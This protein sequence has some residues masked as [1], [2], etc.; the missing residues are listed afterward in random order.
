MKKPANEGR[1]FHAGGGGHRPPSPLRPPPPGA[2]W[3]GARVRERRATLP[4]GC[5]LRSLACQRSLRSRVFD[6]RGAARDHRLV[7]HGGAPRVGILYATAAAALFGLST[8]AAKLLVG[9]VPPVLLASLLYLG[10]GLG[11]VT[12]HL[13]RRARRVAIAP[14][15]T[16]KLPWLVGAIALGGVVAPVLLLTGLRTTPGSTA[17]LLLNLE[18][19]FTALLAWTLGRENA[20]RR[21]VLGMVAIVVGSAL[22]S[23]TGG[24]LGLSLGALAVAGACLC[25]AIDNNLTQA[26]SSADPVFLAGTKG[27][28]A[29]VV[30]LALALSLGMELPSPPVLGAALLVGFAGYG[31][32]LVCFILALRHI[33]TART[34]AYFA[35]APFLGSAASFALLTE[36]P[37]LR[38][39]AAAALMAVGV[40]FHVT[41]QHEH[42][43]AHGGLTHSHRHVHDEHHRHV[44]AP[45]VSEIEPHTHE[46]THEPLVHRHVHAPDIHHR[47]A[48]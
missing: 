42:E 46:H 36:Q 27:L 40:F 43:H 20:D 33:G 4:W 3:H 16:G 2:A 23:W 10:S 22:L 28:V 14:M 39:A 32:S 31:A 44:H 1:L 34:G 48:H 8:P 11:L 30:N 12:I 29:G 35:L 5:S 38:S 19:V 13:L 9:G 25:W 15:P 6:L 45:E 17:S 26:L 18:V 24:G 7:Q 47:H 21:I 37:T 41:E